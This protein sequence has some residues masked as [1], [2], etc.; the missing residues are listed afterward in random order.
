MSFANGWLFQGKRVQVV[1]RPHADDYVVVHGAD[2]D[3]R[4]SRAVGGVGSRVPRF[5]GTVVAGR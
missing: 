5:A 4:W 3:R 1:F 2:V